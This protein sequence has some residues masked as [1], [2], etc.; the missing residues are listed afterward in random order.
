MV[1][2]VQNDWRNVPPL[3]KILVQATWEMSTCFNILDI[4]YVKNGTFF[5][6]CMHHPNSFYWAGKQGGV[7][8]S[9]EAMRWLPLSLFWGFADLY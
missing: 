8:H 7:V 6:F 1:K 4:R 9:V 5:V 3:V 2:V